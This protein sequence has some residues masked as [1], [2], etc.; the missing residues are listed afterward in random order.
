[1]LKYVRRLRNY[2]PT[3]EH[4]LDII[5]DEINPAPSQII[6]QALEEIGLFPTVISEIITQYLTFPCVVEECDVGASKEIDFTSFST[7]IYNEGLR[8]S[9]FKNT[10]SKMGEYEKNEFV[11][12]INYYV[13]SHNWTVL[14]FCDLCWGR[15]V[16]AGLEKMM[17]LMEGVYDDLV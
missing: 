12:Y 10:E 5:V 8:L 11:Y 1:M 15:C 2:N 16:L 13:V 9:P 6:F 17:K 4:L 7:F 14:Y 3:K